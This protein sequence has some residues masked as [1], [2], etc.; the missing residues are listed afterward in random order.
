MNQQRIAWAGENGLKFSPRSID[1]FIWGLG[2]LRLNDK[3]PAELA[4]SD[5]SQVSV[6]EAY[7]RMVAP[8]A[9]IT[10]QSA[11]AEQSE[12]GEL[13]ALDVLTIVADSGVL[14]AVVNSLPSFLKSRKR[15]I[16]VTVTNKSGKKLVVTAD[17]TD[18]VLPILDRLLND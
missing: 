12:W 14:I 16:S 15:G 9:V 11:K 5:H 18:D 7:L 13:G 4:V 2:G 17:S 6:L 3:I 1:R 10:R 8:G